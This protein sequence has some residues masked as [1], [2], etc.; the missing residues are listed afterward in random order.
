MNNERHNPHL[1]SHLRNHKPPTLTFEDKENEMKSDFA[2]DGYSLNSNFA[3]WGNKENRT[4]FAELND[5][6]KSKH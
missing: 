1:S 2:R 3:S 6:S 4:R 5:K